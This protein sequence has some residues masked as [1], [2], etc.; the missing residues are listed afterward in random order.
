MRANKEN[1]VSFAKKFVTGAAIAIAVI[2]FFA[3][4][5]AAGL[6]IYINADTNVDENALVFENSVPEVYDANGNLTTYCS[7][8]EIK[9]ESG[10]IPEHLKNAF[11]ALEDKRFYEHRGVDY[12]R[13]LGATVANLKSGSK[14]QGGSTITQQIVKNAFLSGE[15]SF[16]RKL[17]E[18]RLAVSLERRMSKDE[19]LETYL[20]ML[21]F[22]SGEY[23]VKNAARRFFGC[24]VEDLSIAQSAMLAGIVKSPT[25]YNPINH[26]DN[27][28]ARSRL[29]LDLMFEQ[30]MITKAQYDEAK[31][32][33]IP[34]ADDKSAY[35]FDKTYVVNAL[36]EACSVLGID[37]KELRVR[38]YK[39]YTYLNPA[40]QSV[41]KKTVDD[42][43]MYKTDDTLSAAI[44]A[45]NASGGIC[46]AYSNFSVDFFSFRR[47]SG[48][49]LKPLA[50]Y[51]PAFESGL[52]SPA[53]VLNDEP[54][55][56]GG[57]SPENYG[58][59]YYGKVS[60][61]DA[62]SKSLNVPA[63]S[64]LSSIGVQSGY[65]ALK[66]MDFGLSESDDNLSLAL[67][68]SYYGTSFVELLGGYLTLASYGEYR[69]AHFVSR[70]EDA[71]GNTVFERDENAGK[72]I[73][74]EESSY[75]TTDCLIQCA[76]D[77]TAKK[78]SSLPF[79]IAS[80]TGTVASGEGNA[81]AY[82]VSY[83]SD[84]C[85]LFWQGSERYDDPLP[86]SV[87]GGGLPTLMAK[88]YLSEVYADVKP[89]DFVIPAGVKTAKLD[90]IAYDEGY[91]VLASDNA[92]DRYTVE[93]IFS[94][95]FLPAEKDDSFD[96]PSA[97]S[98]DA[99]VNGKQV[100]IT[101]TAD[102]HICYKVIKKSLFTDDKIILDVENEQGSV[103]VTDE[104]DGL[105]GYN[106]YV[107]VS[108]YLDDD[109]RE[110]IGEVIQIPI[111]W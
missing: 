12:I 81:D 41:L 40:R 100:T 83:T 97:T 80:K 10:K 82:N 79:K 3:M 28:F 69:G 55:D 8:S 38:G 99:S 57:Y 43:S 59:K 24:E 93:E 30:D 56:F 17:K 26:Y 107:I 13:I 109:G 74:S 5:T 66:A 68:S 35:E 45:D 90:K 49:V 6:V 1:N 32:E 31:E 20:N 9:A 47:Q 61:R 65:D 53:S 4:M 11:V 111:G 36:D 106:R 88:T 42:S 104:A 91:L 75:L 48:S 77:G 63:V 50:C 78:L 95:R 39:L 29:V 73:F 33:K 72:R 19:I 52:F 101:F 60:V 71:D 86:S 64:V 84:S 105:L 67:G 87:T 76:T 18:A 37:A 34:I 62:L 15:K 54:T 70:I 103:S 16:S 108:Y 98:L 51:A 58:K 2:V 96:Y 102:P 27:A 94:E 110:T 7:A 14:A 22:G 46:A 23:G 85:M 44:V 92:P 89:F 25:K 21:Y